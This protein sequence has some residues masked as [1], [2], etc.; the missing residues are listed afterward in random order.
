ML[1]MVSATPNGRDCV[2]RLAA[3]LHLPFVPNCLSI[4]LHNDR[5]Q[6]VRS[7]YEDRAYALTRTSQRPAKWLLVKMN[8][9]AARAG[10]I[11]KTAPDSVISGRSIN[12]VREEAA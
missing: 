6:A 8:D 12:D 9:S 3:S 1:V 10:D 5:L 4:D 2:P 7:I 11:T